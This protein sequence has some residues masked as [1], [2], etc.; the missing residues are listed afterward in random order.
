[1]NFRK[2]SPGTPL[3][4]SPAA[5]AGWQNAV[6]ETVQRWLRQLFG[7]DPQQLAAELR[8]KEGRVRVSNGTSDPFFR[9]QCV[10]LDSYRLNEVNHRK[11][12]FVGGEY[13]GGEKWGVLLRG[14]VPGGDQSEVQMLGVC[15]ARVYVSDLNH[16]HANPSNNS[17]DFQSAASGDLE[18]LS[19]PSETGTQ[20]VVVRFTR[21]E[22][23]RTELRAEFSAYHDAS[24]SGNTHGIIEAINPVNLPTGTPAV[25]EDPLYI[26]D[27]HEIGD[28]L[29]SGDIVR[30][31]RNTG[32]DSYG[33]S[34]V[35][36]E[37]NL[38]GAGG[39]AGSFDIGCGLEFNSDILEVDPDALAGHG[40]K[41]GTSGDNCE[42]PGGGEGTNYCCLY[43]DVGCGLR[44]NAIDSDKIEVDID[45]LAGK[46]LIADESTDLCVEES[47]DETSTYCC[48]AINIGCGLK[49]SAD[50]PPKVEVD[51]AALAGKGLG[52]SISGSDCDQESSH[53]PGLYCCLTVNLGCGL[54]F[55]GDD[56]SVDR[57]DLMGDGLTAG[58]GECDM[59][60]AVDGTYI[61]ISGGTVQLDWTAVCNYINNNCGENV[62]VITGCA[63]PFVTFDAS[64]NPTWNFTTRSIRVLKDNGTG[65]PVSCSADGTLTCE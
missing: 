34:D 26:A 57:D 27:I 43:I 55:V 37:C 61:I 29:S 46:G 3:E 65:T 59:D 13:D 5:T 62:T 2:V 19:A 58:S 30:A 20:D 63:D 60:V 10:Q 24:T 6:T 49:F 35:N 47:D 18:F 21:G 50:S 54:K 52:S 8:D 7:G 48:L 1:M 14:L 17:R 42:T 45:A 36:W 39:G 44:F 53:T 23:L 40:I 41:V 11:R 31:I 4:E 16:T 9:G 22:T 15:T 38:D 33:G 12:W 51:V 25:T 56:V 28:T 32:I 64:G